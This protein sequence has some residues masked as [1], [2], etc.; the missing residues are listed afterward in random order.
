MVIATGL[1]LTQVF[2]QRTKVGNQMLALRDKHKQTQG[3]WPAEDDAEFTR[4]STEYDELKTREVELEGERQ[5]VTQREE[6]LKRL[7]DIEQDLKRQR[8]EPGRDDFSARDRGDPRALERDQLLALQ[9][10]LRMAHDK[11]PSREQR[12]AARRCG[13]SLNAKRHR[14]NLTPTELYNTRESAWMSG[15]QPTAQRL[16]RASMSVAVAADGG[17]T[18]P[19]DLILSFENKLLT[20]GGPRPVASVMR[21]SNGNPLGWPGLDDTA[22]TGAQVDELSSLDLDTSV[23]PALSKLTWNAY[24]FTSKSVRV[25]WELLEDS[26]FN[27]AVVLGGLLGERLAR[28]TT[29]KM[30]TAN[31]S[32]TP[33]GVSVGISAGATSSSAT[34]FTADN[35]IELTHS[36]DPGYRVGDKVGF[37]MHDNIV[38]YV[39]KL[40]DGQG[41]YL[42]MQGALA[43]VPDRLA[44][45]PLTIN[46]Y[47]DSAVTASKK[48][49]I[50]GD[51]SKYCIRDVGSLRLRRLE[52]RYADTDEV[53]FIALMRMD[54]RWCNTA[55]AKYLVTAAS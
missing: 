31:G 53:A 7:G 24:K 45:Y 46:Q 42:W 32:G 33:Q 52:E 16:Q 23:N 39:R 19:T 35:V 51:F 40:K 18:I 21:T 12:E 5:R 41:N 29:S 43:G 48:V 47:M 37:M 54:A 30:T 3:D 27:F 6:R 38:V 13:F 26:P 1:T 11:G 15:G 17:H 28:I 44:G 22:N 49:M 55:A 10:W 2:E 25:S 50:F 20:I 8:P 4:M 9:G 36:I 34:A 14:L